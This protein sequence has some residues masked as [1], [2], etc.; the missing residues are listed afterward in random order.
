MESVAW[1]PNSPNIGQRCKL[2]T[3]GN[4]ASRMKRHI[5]A[6][7]KAGC[8][9]SDTILQC[10]IEPYV[11]VLLLTASNNCKR[12][13]KLHRAV[14][15]CVCVSVCV[16]VATI[17]GTIL[18][19]E[20][21]DT[22]LAVAAGVAGESWAHGVDAMVIGHISSRALASDCKGHVGPTTGL[23]NQH[24]MDTWAQALQKLQAKLPHGIPP[25]YPPEA[26][27]Q[28]H[29]ELAG[30]GGSRLQRQRDP[31]RQPGAA[32]QTS[33]S[34]GPRGRSALPTLATLA[35]HEEAMATCR[36]H[37]RLGGLWLAVSH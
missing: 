11:R 37:T 12:F 29:T 15:M 1:K 36:W 28:L 25:H 26:A 5:A 31:V 13:C 32:C 4:V 22:S 16:C 23:G 17:A 21:L 14:C 10:H 34:Q 3:S 18:E 27:P 9:G 19:S 24:A 33:S 20:G 7:V 8:L 2:C 35:F 30:H 6:V